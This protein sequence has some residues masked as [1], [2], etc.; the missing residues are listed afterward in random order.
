MVADLEQGF[1]Y[2]VAMGHIN[3]AAD[4]EEA[5][6]DVDVDS[7]DTGYLAQFAGH[8]WNEKVLEALHKKGHPKAR[9][10][11]GFVFQHLMTGPMSTSSLAVRMGIS[12]Q[13]ASKQVA[14]LM[15]LG[16]V[17]RIAAPNDQRLKLLK[18]TKKAED[19]IATGRAI[20]KDLEAK[21][22]RKVGA[23]VVDATRALLAA[24]LGDDIEA[25]VK[26]RKVKATT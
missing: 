3:A 18:L 26:G 15:R 24:M 6:A 12:Q 22:K 1:R 4:G 16:Y 25:A 2:P 23:D 13:A 8:A 14:A 21:L 17:S 9:T 10:S 19:A 11:H 20:R 5:G 7:L